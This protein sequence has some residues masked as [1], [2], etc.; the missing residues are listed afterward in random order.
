MFLREIV[1][2]YRHNSSSSGYLSG[3]RFCVNS[4]EHSVSINMGKYLNRCAVINFHRGVSGEISRRNNIRNRTVIRPAFSRNLWQIMRQ[5]KSCIKLLNFSAVACRAWLAR[6]EVIAILTLFQLISYFVY[7]TVPEALCFY[8]YSFEIDYDSILYLSF[9]TQLLI[10]ISP[11][12]CN[13]SA[14]GKDGVEGLRIVVHSPLPTSYRYCN[15][16]FELL[17]YS[18]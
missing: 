7:T 1:C 15:R 12:I 10:F 4:D 17:N 8:R 14:A 2:I 18:R 5:I 3:K 11:L 6:S 13:S 9:F 16:H